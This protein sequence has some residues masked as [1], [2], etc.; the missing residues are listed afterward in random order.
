MIDEKLL[1]RITANPELW[2]Q[3]YHSRDVNLSRDDSE[4]ARF[5]LF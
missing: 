3:D 4:P 5:Q 2:R 1:R